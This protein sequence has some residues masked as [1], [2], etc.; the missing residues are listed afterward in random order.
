LP[1]PEAL[2]KEGRFLEAARLFQEKALRQ[3]DVHKRRRFLNFAA[4]CY[5]SA[6]E[7]ALAVKCFLDSGDVDAA[8]GSAVKAK[9]PHVLSNAL[10]DAGRK[11]DVVRFLLRGAL[12]LVEEREFGFARAFCKEALEFGHSDLALILIN[13]VD[14]VVEGKAEK[15]SAGV[16]AVLRASDEDDELAREVVFVANKFLANMP[17]IAG[18][19]KEVPT[20]CPECGAPLPTKIKGKIIV[21]GY[22]GFAVR[23]D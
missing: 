9:N 5:E 22:C 21:C 1:K 10:V 7:Y 20:R 8:V 3:K 16:E 4:R 18:G 23:L 11:A 6:G 12:R 2:V 15:V 14:G 13:V 17:K 19:V